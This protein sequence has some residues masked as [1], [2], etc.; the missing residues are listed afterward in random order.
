MILVNVHA[1]NGEQ[2][3]KNL[4]RK[5]QR[6]LV[7]RSMKMSRFYEPPSVKRVRKDQETERRK[8]KV[9]RKQLMEG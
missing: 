6:E 7:F 2:A 4:K 3:I 9:A 5:M 8:R 1:G